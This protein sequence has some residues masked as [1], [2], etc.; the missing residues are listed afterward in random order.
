MCIK[1]VKEL[2]WSKVRVAGL[3]D[4]WEWTA[5]LTVNGYGRFSSGRNYEVP[6]HSN[7]T[8]W[9][10]T[11]GPIPP[12]LDILHSCDN[13][14]CCN[15][16]HLRLGTH[17]DNMADRD[18]RRGVYQCSGESHGRA[19]LSW[20]Q[21]SEIR[22]SNESRSE[23]SR[24]FGVSK[25]QISKIRLGQLWTRRKDCPRLSC[26]FTIVPNFPIMKVLIQKSKTLF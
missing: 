21:V 25:S 10:L 20:G 4:C 24:K 9:H 2:F 19:K 11:H 15:P 12:G 5:S 13:R 18:S 7:R 23:L 26:P 6:Q 3:D 8:V 1:R 22:G 17:Q 14:K 16:T